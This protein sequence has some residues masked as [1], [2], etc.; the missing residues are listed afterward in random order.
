MDCEVCNCHVERQFAR[1]RRSKK[2]Q[3]NIMKDAYDGMNIELDMALV[4][5]EL[6]EVLIAR[7][8]TKTLKLYNY[9]N[10]DKCC[11]VCYEDVDTFKGKF[12]CS[13]CFCVECIEK[14]DIC[15]LCRADAV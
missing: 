1:H 4:N 3:Y 7:K 11:S 2:H 6:I 9:E 5:I 14:L 12:K 15:A 8:K 10:N 13:H